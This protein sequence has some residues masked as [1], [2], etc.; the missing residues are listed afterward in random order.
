ME[1]AFH[2][3]G[4]V[5]LVG[6]QGSYSNLQVAFGRCIL[7]RDPI[8]SNYHT[9]ILY[10]KIQNIKEQSINS[11]PKIYSFSIVIKDLDL[12][13]EALER[14]PRESNKLFSKPN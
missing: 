12:D 9:K 3:V 13:M 4:K 5:S 14:C 8:V 1:V 7:R 11:D 2:R 10:K 6:V